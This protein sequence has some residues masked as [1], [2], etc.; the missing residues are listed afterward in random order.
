MTPGLAD[1]VV[2]PQMPRHDA[3]HVFQVRGASADTIALDGPAQM[4]DRVVAVE[5]VWRHRDVGH[6][7]K[8]NEL[9]E[10]PGDEPRPLGRNDV[11]LKS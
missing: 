2:M 10:V 4:V 5:I 6:A 7:T 3:T 11:R 1:R 8:T 9:L